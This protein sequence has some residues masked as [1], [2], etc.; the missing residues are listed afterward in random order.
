MN[1]CHSSQAISSCT[2]CSK[3]YSWVSRDVMCFH[4]SRV[5]VLFHFLLGIPS[6]HCSSI[7]HLLLFLCPPPA[8][9]LMKNSEHSPIWKTTSTLTCLHHCTSFV[10]APMRPHCTLLLH[11]GLY[12]CLVSSLTSGVMFYSSLHSLV[13]T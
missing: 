1:I 8:I 5:R 7:E 11:D 2:A 6:P 4:D 12:H 3:P 9:F 13:L 10:P